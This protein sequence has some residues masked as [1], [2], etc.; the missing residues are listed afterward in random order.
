MTMKR[1]LLCLALAA[2]LLLA[3]LPLS[4]AAATASSYPDVKAT[5]WY[6]YAVE[7]AT[8]QQSINGYEVQIIN[9]YEDGT[10]GPNKDVTRAQMV[11]MLWS[12]EGRPQVETE[13]FSDIRE[14]TWF[15]P[16]VNWASANDVVNGYEDHTFRPNH[17]ASREQLVTILYKY[18]RLRGADLSARADLS[19]FSDAG[20]VS[21]YALT[22]MQWAVAEGLINGTT[23]TTLS[24]QST[25]SRAQVVS[26]L[27]RWLAEYTLKDAH[28]YRESLDEDETVTLRY[29]RETPH[30]PA[31][32]LMDYYNTFW[33]VRSSLPEM[34][35]ERDGE[36]FVFTSSLGAVARVNPGTDVMTVDNFA[37]FVNPPKDFAAEPDSNPV[38]FLAGSEILGDV[39]DPLPWTVDF[40]QYGIDLQEDSEDVFF[41]LDT[42]SNLF[43][44]QSHYYTLFNG[45]AIYLSDIGNVLDHAVN[46]TAPDYYSF[47]SGSRPGDVVEHSYQEL[48]FCLEHFYGQ[49]A[50]ALLHDAVANRTLDAALQDQYPAIY[51]WLHSTNYVQYTAGLF[52][53]FNGPLSDGGHTGFFDFAWAG[54]GAGSIFL[55]AMEQMGLEYQP[56]AVRSLRIQNEL[57]ALRREMLGE[58]YYYEQG[59][60]AFFTFDS[61]DLDIP[62]WKAYYQALRNGEVPTTL[63]NDVTMK[64]IEALETAQS[65]PNILNFVVD[66]STNGGGVVQVGAFMIDLMT[67]YCRINDE[68]L[69]TG[70]RSSVHY[71]FDRNLDNQLDE[72][73]DQIQFDLNFAVLVSPY[74]FSCANTMAAAMKDAGVLVMGETSGGGS[75][76]TENDAVLDGFV[77]QM[78]S[79]YRILTKD[80]E[81]TDV[82]VTPDVTLVKQLEDGTPDYR[83]FYDLQVLSDVID[84]YYSNAK[85][86]A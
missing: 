33:H 29:Y 86:A 53:L 69:T 47:V 14:G 51:S 32:G 5:S 80:G 21:S 13:S 16:A 1:R 6:A 17:S 52:A 58:E 26:I 46:Q 63:P 18:A 38:P 59:D 50:S 12:L 75:C 23:S 67:G 85:A 11:K 45:K 84:G 66:L 36:D 57:T 68:V 79:G 25:A 3:G 49:P 27:Y 35:V 74:S 28:V 77:Y 65:N 83:D 73:D 81:D 62:G 56:R 44:S 43:G 64:F 19:G 70:Q 78:S 2:T 15:A 22:P 34:T 55:Q 40:S 7:W 76:V 42:L 82:G 31:M 39:A 24:P 48:L 71:L 37:L 60:T 61:F 20:L 9:G 8:R 4:A 72:M 10:F 54:A 41:P 30:V